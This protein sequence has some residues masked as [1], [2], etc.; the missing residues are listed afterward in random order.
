[1]TAEQQQEKKR[2]PWLKWYPADWRQ[3]I[4]LR[5]CSRA[6][7]SLWLD[8]L[9][10]MHESAVRGHLLINGVAPDVMT[11][12]DALGDSPRD[13]R[14]WLDELELKG[15]F[16]RLEDGT[17]IS[18]RM[19]RDTAKA[20][21]DKANG[22]TGGNPKLKA[23]DNPE[24]PKGDKEG[25]N[26]QDKAHMPEARIQNVVVPADAET[27]N[28]GSDLIEAF[29]AALIATW[30]ER[31]R[32]RKPH[33]T[34]AKT[35]RQWAADGLTT[36][37]AAEVFRIHCGKMQERGTARL[38]WS[39]KV[40]E[41]D[42]RGALAAAAAR[43]VAAA[44]GERRESDDRARWRSRLTGYAAGSP[45]VTGWGPKP[46]ERG[47]DAPADLVAEILGDLRQEVAL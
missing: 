19:V 45:W 16:S 7:R 13:I 11:L 15:V 28:N 1:M 39:L 37:M 30:G 25:V 22:K 38:P 5:T 40:F 36:S 12:A 31:A 10:L 8:M 9:G 46:G 27:N 26:P 44:S 24:G 20:A 34:D 32:R 29:D 17:I 3:E 6:A 4:T 35:A 23:S 2:H 43:P 21:R 14:R 18:R 33:A 41:D 47:C 42:V